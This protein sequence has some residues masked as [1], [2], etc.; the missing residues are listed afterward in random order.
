MEKRMIN[1]QYI[2]SDDYQPTYANGAYGGTT[3][4]GEIVINFFTEG[5]AIPKKETAELTESGEMMNEQSIEPSNTN[6]I[7]KISSGV[8]MTRETADQIYN[9]LGTILGKDQ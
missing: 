6:V 9:W 4:R 2:F 7:R 8:I 1:F 3:P 5:W